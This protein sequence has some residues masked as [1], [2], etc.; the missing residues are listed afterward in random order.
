MS[1]RGPFDIIM[2][3]DVLEHLPSPDD[4]L[5]LAM[6]GLKPGGIIL[7][8]VPNVAHWSLRL[9]LLFGRFTIRRQACATLR[10]CVGLHSA[11]SGT[12]SPTTVLRFYL[13]GVAVALLF[14]YIG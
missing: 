3:A 10:T 11:R 8:S 2:F 14:P 7:A 5:K 6:S 13:C 1:T 12:C 9:E 4:M